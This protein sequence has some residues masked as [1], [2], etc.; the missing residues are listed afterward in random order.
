[1]TTALKAPAQVSRETEM[2][3]W[4]GW[5]PGCC[6]RRQRSS[7][8][9]PHGLSSCL[10]HPFHSLSEGTACIDPPANPRMTREGCVCACAC[11]CVRVRVCVCVYACM[12]AHAR[13]CVRVWLCVCGCL[14][15]CTC[16]HVQVCLSVVLYGHTTQFTRRCQAGCGG[17]VVIVVS[18]EMRAGVVAAG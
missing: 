16:A 1:L 5:G 12:R 2:S 14:C 8:L 18:A 6:H 7:L 15:V 17:A 10:S 11:V 9:R 4:A 3:F 13:V